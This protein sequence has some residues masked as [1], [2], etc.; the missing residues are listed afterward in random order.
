ME[1]KYFSRGGMYPYQAEGKIEEIYFY[2]RYR[3]D[4]ASLT[5]FNTS[6]APSVFK[7]SIRYFLSSFTWITPI[8]SVFAYF[9]ASRSD[10]SLI[11]NAFQKLNA[12]ENGIRV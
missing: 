3:H 4:K 5:L 1:I 6:L 12:A 9:A 8:K 2:F 11:N 7:V 10:I